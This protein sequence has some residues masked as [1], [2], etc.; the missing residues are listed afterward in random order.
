MGGVLWFR[1]VTM[2]KSEIVVNYFMKILQINDHLVAIGD[3]IE[4]PELVTT[5]LNGFSPL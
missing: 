2:N 5:T 1:N 4:D 3:T